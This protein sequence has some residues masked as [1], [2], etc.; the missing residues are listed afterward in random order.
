MDYTLQ[1]HSISSLIYFFGSES[2][3]FKMTRRMVRALKKARFPTTTFE[4]G[5]KQRIGD[6]VR[7]GVSYRAEIPTAKK[8]ADECCWIGKLVL[9]SW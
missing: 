3:L 4:G 7:D 9:E 1:N 8:F 5:N 2:S 6:L